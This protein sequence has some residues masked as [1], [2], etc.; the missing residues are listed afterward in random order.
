MDLNWIWV[1]HF[2]TGQ[3]FSSLPEGT[4][5]LKQNEKKEEKEWKPTFTY[6]IV[7]FKLQQ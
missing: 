2:I 6:N 4:F 7:D 5:K 1:G 3:A